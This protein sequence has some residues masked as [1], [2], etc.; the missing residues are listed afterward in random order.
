MIEI[1][2]KQ[3]KAVSAPKPAVSGRLFQETLRYA[4]LSDGFTQAPWVS[5][6][7][8]FRAQSECLPLVGRLP[9]GSMDEDFALRAPACVIDHPI[10][11]VARENK[12]KSDW[13]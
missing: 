11:R 1:W 7:F 12:P 5:W 2:R 6:T 13:D 10:Y 8:L 9:T 4:G 3:A